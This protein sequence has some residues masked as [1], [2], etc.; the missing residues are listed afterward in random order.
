MLPSIAETCSEGG[1]QTLAPKYCFRSGLLRCNGGK[2]RQYYYL[3]HI[4]GV[5]GGGGKGKEFQGVCAWEM[6]L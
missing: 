3:L 2:C 4:V 6:L 1:W 5:G